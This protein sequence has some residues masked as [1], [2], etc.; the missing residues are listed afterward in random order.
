MAPVS[1]GGLSGEKG[2]AGAALGE[3][4]CGLKLGFPE[5]V[6]RLEIKRSDGSHSFLIDTNYV[7]WAGCAA[8]LGSVGAEAAAGINKELMLGWCEV[9]LIEAAWGCKRSTR[10]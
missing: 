10:L 8:W 3:A 2:V 9:S 1:S 6:S 7:E 5:P 4:S